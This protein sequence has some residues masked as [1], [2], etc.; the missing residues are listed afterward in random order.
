VPQEWWNASVAAGFPIAIQPEGGGTLASM[1][2]QGISTTH[3][4]GQP[5]SCNPVYAHPHPQPQPQPQPQLSN[6]STANGSR[7]DERINGTVNNT[8][9]QFVDR[10]KWLESRHMTNVCGDRVSTAI[11]TRGCCAIGIHDVAGVET[12]PR[13]DPI[14]CLLG[15]IT[16]CQQ[17]FCCNTESGTGGVMMGQALTM[18]SGT[19][20]MTS[21]H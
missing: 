5:P 18:D 10:Y 2:W 1:S 11:C 7:V 12:R 3:C 16:R 6:P 9:V 20:L 14:T 15:V 4:D 17:E 21:Q 8:Y 19:A 13:C